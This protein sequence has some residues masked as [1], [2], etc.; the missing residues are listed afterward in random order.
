MIQKALKTVFCVWAV[1]ALS[2]GTACGQNTADKGA[3]GGGNS[4]AETQNPATM[5]E[6]TFEN[7]IGHAVSITKNTDPEYCLEDGND[8]SFSY[9]PT[10]TWTFWRFKNS[11]QIDWS[12]LKELKFSVYNPNY[13]YDY[14]FTVSLSETLELNHDVLSETFGTSYKARSGEWTEFTISAEAAQKVYEKG[15]KYL[16][17]AMSYPSNGG[18]QSEQ[19]LQAHLYFDGFESVPKD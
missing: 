3:N 7:A 15:M 9:R 17:M 16:S 10:G 2:M 12:N 5:Y 8:W 11:D 13:E 4:N 18:Y 19:W 6:F 14:V 1:L